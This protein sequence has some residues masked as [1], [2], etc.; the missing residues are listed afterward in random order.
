MAGSLVGLASLAFYSEPS[1]KARNIA[2]GASIGLY[3]GILLGS[4]MVYVLPEL[5]KAPAQRTLTPEEESPDSIDVSGW[6]IAP[7]FDSTASS[8][9]QPAWVGSL[10]LRF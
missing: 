4:Y 8:G 1:K 7:Q 3:A 2:L 6:G 5:Q 9:D 10:A